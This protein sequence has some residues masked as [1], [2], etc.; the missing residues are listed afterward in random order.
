MSMVRMS[1]TIPM[2]LAHKLDEIAGG[3]KKSQFIT[4][5]LREHIQRIEQ[6]ELQDSLT[7]GYKARKAES[8]DMAREFEPLDL[9]GWDEY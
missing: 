8:L 6:E 9:D 5:S 7:E 1:I 4:E 3:R 2:E